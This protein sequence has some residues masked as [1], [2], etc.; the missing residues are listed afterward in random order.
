MTG[1]LQSLR[2]GIGMP[3]KRMVGS[4]LLDWMILV[5]TVICAFSLSRVTPN[6]QPFSL[7][8]P[9]IS[10]P[11][12]TTTKVP[13]LALFFIATVAPTIILFV[14]C[15]VF[16]PG[17]AADPRAPRAVRWR[18]K[19]WA[20]NTAWLGLGLAVVSA[21]LVTDLGKTFFGKPR[22]DLLSR[23]N[24]DLDRI[25]ENTVSG[26]GDRL[27]GGAIMVRHTICRSEVDLKDGFRSF[28]SGH[29]SLSF[30]SMTYLTLWI[31]SKFFIAVPKYAYGRA[32]PS[33][34]TS[35]SHPPLPVQHTDPDGPS[36]H[37]KKH[38]RLPSADAMDYLCPDALPSPV[39]H[40]AAAPPLYLVVLAFV[41]LGV[42]LYVA[43]T[44]YS[45]YRHHGFDILSGSVLGVA[46][47]FLGFRWYHLPIRDG[48]GGSWTARA[49]DRA[50]GIGVGVGSYVHLDDARSTG[51]ATDHQSHDHQPLPTNQDVEL[52]EIRRPAPS[53]GPSIPDEGTAY[54]SPMR[55]DR[56]DG[57]VV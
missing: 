22:P 37:R 5:A 14:L 53:L 19:L 11:Y 17:R 10:L 12:S 46:S 36:T 9:K 42:A 35:A 44:R 24:P 34:S 15:M 29:A 2:D 38:Q 13:T 27:S 45:D 52:G 39:Q 55:H 49:P 23:C 56:F 32:R 57:G 26:F 41:P 50:F 25:K 33:S 1:F 8:D 47:A 54:R 28:P 3:S 40:H 4:Y 20:L 7:V 21:Q 43:S 48:S 51:R 30:A 18:R 31:C 6:M 16:V